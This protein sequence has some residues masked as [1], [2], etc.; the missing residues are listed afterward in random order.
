[1]VGDVTET[2]IKS[3][4]SF[5][6]KWQKKQVTVPDADTT[7]KP[8][9]ANTVYLVN[10]PHAAQ[11]EIR[12]GYVTGL[13]YDATGTFYK[14]GLVNYTLGGGFN[15]RLNLDLR[16]EKG[17]TYGASSGFN[18]G[19]YGGVF[20]ASA[21]VRA[22]ATDS[23]VTEFVQ[24]I[25]RYAANGITPA[26]LAFTKS[27]IGQ[28]DALKYETNN[29]KGAFLSR[30]QNYNLKANFVDEQNTI[31]AGITTDQINE[32]A[33]KYLDPVKMSIL[34]VGDKDKVMIGLQKL[35][36]QIIELDADGNPK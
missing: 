17:W 36:Y 33:K 14:L 9:A 4:I 25:K 34:V 16:E 35:G 13:N 26:E 27:S 30:I 22:S 19:K 28:S 24:D 23:A 7:T 11:S 29:Q 15:S 21:G 32:L 8:V 31:L 20:I 1:M 18:S 2:E 6:D 12:I 5:L 10:V 3:K